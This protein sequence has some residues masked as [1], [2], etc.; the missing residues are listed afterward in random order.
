ML[1]SLT[2]PWELVADCS[3]PVPRDVSKAL[4]ELGVE[5]VR[6]VSRPGSTELLARCPAHPALVGKVDRRPSFSVNAHTG[7]FLCFSCGYSG[8]FIQLVEDGLGLS[9]I[10]AFRW[11]SRHGV[12]RHGDS[13]EDGRPAD[14]EPQLT[15]ASLALFTQPPQEALRSRH[16]DSTSCA[17]LGVLWD[18]A[19]AHWIIPIRDPHTGELWGWQEKGKRY[20]KNHPAGVQKSRTLFGDTS[21]RGDRALL[22]ES[23]L[24][25]VRVHALGIQGGFASY[26]AHVSEAQM[27][28]LKSWCRCLVLGLDNDKTGRASRDQLYARWRPFGLPM[29]FLDY[30]EISAKDT[31]D[32]T[33]D[34]IIRSYSNAYRPW[35]CR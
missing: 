28:L 6:E 21:W 14:E 1:P 7:L 29:R 12:Y 18:P 4:G 35:R 34:E 19:T 32:M 22:V 25:V 17:E 33:D 9:R 23:P 8:A 20:F 3:N 15:E 30:R 10:D 11:I 5:V 27:R 31:G 16:L 24:D 2:D 13:Q 26:G